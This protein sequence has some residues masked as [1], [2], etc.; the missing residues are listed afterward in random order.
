MIINSS[1]IV[2]AN[3]LN[4]EVGRVKRMLQ[5]RSE[6]VVFDD[7]RPQFVIV[8]LERAALCVEENVAPSQFEGGSRKKIGE[9]VQS[10]MKKFF[11]SG[12]LTNSDI[13][14]LTQPEYSKRT[15]NLNSCVLK[16]VD[17]SLPEDEQRMD[18]RGYK[19]FYREALSKNGK[20]YLLS[21]QWL[22]ERHRSPFEAWE[23]MIENR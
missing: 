2:S 7:N 5:V 18:A 1:N 21:S 17:S 6:I 20:R 15:F 10:T 23:N 14:L 11:Y 13:E 19:R 22:E 16:E 9:L 3:E 4:L 12:R 8:S